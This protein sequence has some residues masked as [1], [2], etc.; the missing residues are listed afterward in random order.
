M[1]ALS[2]TK[3][4]VG[5]ASPSQ[6]S[7]RDVSAHLTELLASLGF[8]TER[9]T[10]QSESGVEKVNVVGRKGQFDTA[11]RGLA[12]F[13]HSDVV[14]AETW[15]GPGEA[16]RATESDGKLYGRGSCDMKG[17][18]ACMLAA[19]HR[20][21]AE[22]A[23]A[24]LYFVCTADEEI[25]YL[26]AKHLVEHSAFYRDIVAR[27]TR[28]L[29]GE[30]TEL[31]V[32]HAHKGICTI[33]IV[34]HGEAAHS[35][36][37]AGRN[38]NLAMIPFL[39]EMKTIYDETETQSQ[40][41]NPEFDP[42]TVSWN[43][44]IRDN[45]KALNVKPS[46]CECTVFYRPLPGLDDQRLLDRTKAAAEQFGLDFQFARANSVYTNPRNRFVQESLALSQQDE[47][48]TVSYGTDAAEFTEL[49]H[50]IV[51]GPGAIAQAHTTD[52]W[53]DLAQ[54]EQGT[55]LYERFLR[56]WCYAEDS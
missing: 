47:P 19:I 23:N 25:G 48:R 18:A 27:Q 2:L 30:P 11:E 13:C 15:T 50:K 39:Q 9:T 43:I 35:S 40:W 52:E 12:Y 46:R 14:P 26:G 32:V 29:I 33:R 24:P 54:L 22:E 21:L 45:T 49:H 37:R 16:F 38:A 44:G 36:T 6:L 17:S 7:N 31:S 20:C 8:E 56:R 10:Y 53:I 28:A 4:L 42:P 51:C 34:S 1:D 55:D 41:Q 3:Q 5:F